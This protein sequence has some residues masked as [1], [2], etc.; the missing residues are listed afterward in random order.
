MGRILSLC[1]AGLL[2]LS[3]GL[4][5]GCADEHIAT[6]REV[7][8]DNGEIRE[9]RTTVTEDDGQVQVERRTTER[10]RDDGTVR[11][12]TEVERETYESTEEAV[13]EME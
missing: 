3:V 5:A 12:E 9:Q 11:Q 4:A 1:G 13:D 2:V 7:E 6:E 10:E 8:I